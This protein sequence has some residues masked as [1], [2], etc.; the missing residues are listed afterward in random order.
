MIVTHKITADITRRGLTPRIEAAQND[1]YSRDLQIRLMS[2]GAT[3]TPP[4]GCTV[5]IRY[6]REDRSGGVYDALPDGGSAWSLSQNIL[7]VALAPQVCAKA[8]MVDLSVTLLLGAAE[9]C[10][11]TLQVDVR[12]VPTVTGSSDPYFNVTHFVPQPEG[13]EVGQYLKIVGVDSLGRA[14]VVGADT[15]GASTLE[16]PEAVTLEYGAQP[17]VTELDDSRAWARIY[18]LGIPQ[19]KPGDTPVRGTDY[20]TQADQEAILTQAEAYISDRLADLGQV[21]VNF[22]NSIDECSDTSKVYVLPDGYLYGYLLSDGGPNFTNL[23][24][25]DSSDWVTDYRINSSGSLVSA[26]GVL[27]TNYID[28]AS[29]AEVHLKGLD[30]VNAAASGNNYGRVYAYNADKTYLA[31]GQPSTKTA[32][33]PAADYDDTVTVADI[34]SILSYWFTASE[35][36]YIRFGGFLTV[37]SADD[38]VITA[39]QEITYSESGYAWQNTGHAFV[40]ADYEDRI[41]ALEDQAQEQAE[42]LEE[43]SSRDWNDSTA[44]PDYWQD[45]VD[46]AVSKVKALQD[47]SGKDLVN[48]LWFSDL[49]YVPDDVYVSNIGTLCAGVMDAC[50]IPLTLM[51]GDT[52]SAAVVDSEEKLLQWLD[53]A[54]EVLS[55]IGTQRLLQIRGNHDDVYGSYTADGVSAYYVNKVAPAKIWNRIHRPQ[56]TDFRR[57]FGGDGTYFYLDNVPQKIRFICLNSQFYDGSGITDGTEKAMTNGFGDIQL[58][59]L[60]NTALA[61]PDGWDVIIAT[62]IP[63]AATAI[64]GTVYLSQYSDGEAFRDIIQNS[65]ASI[66]GIFCGHCHVDAIVTDDLPCPVLTIT[67][68]INTPYDGTSADRVAGTDTETALDIVSID[69][70]TKTIHLTRLGAGSDRECSYSG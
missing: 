18:R 45:A 46:A 15:G 10:C 44:I 28:I 43:L 25:P 5:L 58:D 62:H 3:F 48:F 13:A 21:E 7:T 16:I 69:R 1:K 68:A 53:G 57:V 20:W 9:L 26:G 35:V 30:I 70:N 11:L 8:G 47:E 14:T 56:A 22:A 4:E 65:A 2:N 38:V 32:Y 12:P 27:I 41:L 29:A 36:R 59:W 50:S 66:L 33:F 63:P 40:P 31:Y 54:A 55:P 51:S 67:C 49:H 37:D 23:A 24:D 39:D 17:T 42:A 61:V 52:M 64:N 19:G 6:Q 34:T 60:E